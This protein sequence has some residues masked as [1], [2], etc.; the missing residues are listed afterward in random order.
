MIHKLAVCT[1]ALTLCGLHTPAMGQD[2]PFESYVYAGAGPMLWIYV[3][4]QVEGAAVGAGLQGRLGV[5]ITDMI[6]IEGRYAA[7]GEDDLGGVDVSLEGAGSLLLTL[8][9]EIGN[10][11]RIG[12]YGGAT[13]GKMKFS[14]G[15]YW[16]EDSD[17]GP[18]LGAFV[19]LAI[20]EN[21]YTYLDYGTYLWKS[22]YMV[23]GVSVG[24][25]VSF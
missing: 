14:Y 23:Q 3:N 4:D 17:S 22:D 6:G 11:H 9:S 5:Q 21:L 8:S 1:A 18:S 7:G 2:D 24:L 16:G 10:N 20:T 15:P 25:G 19:N 12:V 13:A